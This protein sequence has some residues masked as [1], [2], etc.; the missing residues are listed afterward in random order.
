[1]SNSN[2]GHQTSWKNMR[3][4]VTRRQGLS[5]NRVVQMPK[6]QQSASRNHSVDRIND[7]ASAYCS[8]LWFQCCRITLRSLTFCHSETRKQ[9][10]PETSTYWTSEMLLAE[11][12]P[13]QERWETSRLPEGTNTVINSN[14]QETTF[15][16]HWLLCTAFWDSW[17]KS[18]WDLLAPYCASHRSIIKQYYT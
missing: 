17:A 5:S 1:M 11:P 18:F 2:H 12:V 9:K 13:L 7:S 10:N 6:L 15:T 14:N 3:N 8:I 4:N 16:A